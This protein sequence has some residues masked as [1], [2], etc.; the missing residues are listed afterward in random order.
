MEYTDT[1][2]LITGAIAQFGA[3]GIGILGAVLALALGIFVFHWGWKT[4]MNLPGGFGY[5]PQYGS[6]MSRFRKTNYNNTVGGKMKSY[7]F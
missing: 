1:S 5:N 7:R 4:I 3:L 2:S 6:G